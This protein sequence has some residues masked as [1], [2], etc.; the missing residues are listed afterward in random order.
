MEYHDGTAPP[1]GLLAGA[2]GCAL[3]IFVQNKAEFVLT[4]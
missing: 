2:A 1:S 3:A 4:R